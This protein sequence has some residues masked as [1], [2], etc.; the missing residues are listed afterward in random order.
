MTAAREAPARQDTCRAVRPDS[1]RAE[2]RAAQ[3]RRRRLAELGL[4]STDLVDAQPVRDHVRALQAA[5]MPWK[6][7]AAAA[8]LHSSTVSHLLYGDARGYPPSTRIR[9]ETAD[10]LLAVRAESSAVGTRRRL[11]ALVAIGWTSRA[12]ADRLG[13]N[14][15]NFCRLIVGDQRVR[16]D[17]ARKVRD[18]YARLLHVLPPEDTA[19]EKRAAARARRR[20]QALGWVSPL[21]WEDGDIDDPT[22]RPVR[23]RRPGGDV[24]ELAVE[25]LVAGRITAD[26]TG[27]AERAAAVAQLTADDLSAAEI[28]VRIGMHKRSVVR[29]RA[30][31]T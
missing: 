2:W 1:L 25:D 14:D 15:R 28:A 26:R 21:A 22:A 13:W 10:A 29:L 4:P 5:G 16:P 20:A 27:P 6:R 11:Q 12:L 31:A 3:R 8:G 9:P 23:G 18:L 30:V 17:T 19:A 7:I 24:D